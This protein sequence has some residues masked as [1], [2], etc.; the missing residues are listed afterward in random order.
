MGLLEDIK[1]KIDQLTSETT[2]TIY[3]GDMPDNLNVLAIYPTGGFAPNHT[4]NI[5][6]ASVNSPTFQIILKDSNF[7]NAYTRLN[8]IKNALSGVSMQSTDLL[9]Y[10]TIFGLSDIINL[11]KDKNQRTILSLNFVC[12][13]TN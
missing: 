3:I 9:T 6:S 12:K 1:T 4:L 2:S 7:S 13:I 8:S 11:G 10:I 5:Q